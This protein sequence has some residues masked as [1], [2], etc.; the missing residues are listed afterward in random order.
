MV[1]RRDDWLDLAR[2]VDWTP[3][4]VD[5]RELFPEEISGRPWLPHEAWRDWNE[6]YRTTYREYVANQREK[7][8]AVLGVRAALSK[9]RLFDDL[10][11]GWVQL[12][13]FHNGAFALAEYAATVSEQRMARFGRDSAWRTMATLGALDEIR[14]A[15]IPLLIGHDLLAHD[16]NFDW[17]HKAFHTNEWVMLAARHLFDDMFL[18]ADAIDAAI[19][20]NFVFE[21]GFTNL[22]FMAMAAM[23]DRAH[24][25]LFEK[26]VASIQ[27]DEARHAQIGHPV[28]RTLQENGS[29]ERAQYLID[30]MWWRCWRL[31]LA[32]SGTAMEYL[33]PVSA[34]TRSFKEFMTEWV[35]EQFMKNLA[36]FDLEKPWFWDLFTEELDYAHHSF[37]LG[38][39]TYRT[40]LWFDVA[41]P[42]A[43]EREWLNA[44]VPP[45]GGDLRGALGPAR[46][47][48][49]G[50]R[51][52]RHAVLRAA[53]A[54]QFVPAPRAVH[55]ARAE[56]GVHPRAGWPPLPVLLRAVPLDLPAG[57]LA[58]R[59]SPQRDR[60]DRRRRGAR[61]PHRPARRG[62]DCS[63]GRDR[64]G[65]APRHRPVAPS[66]HSDALRARAMRVYLFG[67]ASDDF[68]GRVIVTPDE[69]TVAQLADSWWP[70]AS[71]PNVADP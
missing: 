66:P 46:A 60:P 8:A 23:A 42:D 2:K 28:L 67:F 17:T 12:V 54:L 63:A 1:L 19:Q 52:G 18:A 59:G 29:R 14:H 64:Q 22:Q 38:L 24:H 16:G 35:T 30:K 6:V 58:V 55:Q 37:Q 65:P 5:E 41:M 13:K 39:Y 15:Q 44:E 57:E 45:V 49:G 20:L 36:E 61:Q 47:A 25:H 71:R 51:R 10:D 32:L 7:D 34:R 53:R 3:R 70:G 27:T 9:P 31:F 69:R 33:A 68:L 26:M 50:R 43:A 21:T 48:L 56:H 4:Y 11:P 40:T 62:W